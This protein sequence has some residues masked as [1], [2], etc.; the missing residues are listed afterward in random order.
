MTDD[1]ISF[2][3]L[4]KIDIITYENMRKNATGQT[5]DCIDG[6]LLDYLNLRENQKS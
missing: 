3:Q 6:C 4:I 5:E 1:T 2:D